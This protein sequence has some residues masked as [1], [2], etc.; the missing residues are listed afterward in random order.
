MGVFLAVALLL[1]LINGLFFFI[2]KNAVRRLG[3]F[4]RLNLLHK[5]NIYDE[6]IENKDAELKELLSEIEEAK[7]KA[8][9][10]SAPGMRRVRRARETRSGAW[11]ILPLLGRARET[12]D[13]AESYR[14]LR[15]SLFSDT[16]LCAEAAMRRI[17]EEQPRAALTEAARAGRNPAEEILSALDIET[18]CGLC[19]IEASEAFDILDQAFED[20]DQRALLYEYR[21]SGGT[22][23]TG[24]FD[25]LTVKSFTRAPEIV[26]RAGN[27]ESRFSAL[28]PC[29]RRVVIERDESVCEGLYAIAGG[30]LY[31]YSVRNGVV[32][33]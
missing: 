27:E 33:G 25:D 5:A 14:L 3:K 31:D 18:R 30:R 10:F 23:V 6:L 13:F 4:S 19:L 24:F 26:I 29:G 12:S 11:D 16:A 22:G 7:M 2:L 28:A 20:G 1:L 8:S 15:N 9:G 32:N 21:A 17:E